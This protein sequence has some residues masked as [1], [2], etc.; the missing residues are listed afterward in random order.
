MKNKSFTFGERVVMHAKPNQLFK[1]NWE[2]EVY[3]TGIQ[4]W[5][6]K[7]DENGNGI[8]TRRLGVNWDSLY[9][10]MVGVTACVVLIGYLYAIVTMP[11]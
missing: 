2:C 5:T 8:P 6:Q 4:I 9:N 1:W 7:V 11:Y 3:S 10:L